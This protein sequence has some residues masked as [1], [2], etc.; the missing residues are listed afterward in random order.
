LAH[1]DVDSSS[2]FGFNWP[3]FRKL[4][5]LQVTSDILEDGIAEA[6]SSYRPD[7]LSVARPQRQSTGAKHKALQRM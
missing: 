7:A 1:Y 3:I 2:L 6:G 4:G 5:L